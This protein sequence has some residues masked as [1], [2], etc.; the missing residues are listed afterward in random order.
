MDGF[1]ERKRER[2]QLAEKKRGVKRYLRKE[3]AESSR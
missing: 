3:R 2:E 1:C